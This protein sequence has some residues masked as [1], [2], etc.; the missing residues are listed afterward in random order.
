MSTTALDLIKGSLRLLRVLSPDTDLSNEEANDGLNA[1]NQMLDSWSLESLNLYHT[2]REELTLTSGLNPHT[3]GTGGTLNTARPI[4]IT[5][6]ALKDGGGQIFEIGIVDADTY[7]RV[8]IQ[9]IQNTYPMYLYYDPDY[10]LGKIYLYPVPMGNTLL[11][12]S[13]K[14]LTSFAALTDAVTLPP[15]YLRLL[16]Y[17]LAAELAPEYQTT[18][19]ADI[20][21]ILQES[22]MA[23]K[24]VNHRPQPMQHD[25]AILNPRRGRYSVYRDG[26]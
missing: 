14:A 25:R 15:G 22:K 5:Y 1:L 16:R 23:V 8:K 4:E 20:L 24:V 10:P 7:D 2:T 6:A 13:N 19:G 3:I 21:R 17:G 11:L 9:T 12:H 18:A 26:Q